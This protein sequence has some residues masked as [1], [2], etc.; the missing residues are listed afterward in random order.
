MPEKT[1]PAGVFIVDTNEATGLV[2]NLKIDVGLLDRA[3]RGDFVRVLLKFKKPAVPEVPA[4]KNPNTQPPIP[5]IPENP[6]AHE[7]ITVVVANRTPQGFL[8][9]RV[10]SR[11]QFTQL[12]SITYGDDLTISDRYV[13]SHE[14]STPATA[15]EMEPLL[16]G[17]IPDAAPINAEDAKLRD[18]IKN[19]PP[20]A[21]N[22]Q[23]QYWL[24]NGTLVTV[25]MFHAGVWVGAG[26]NGTNYE[27]LATGAHAGG[28]RE[29]DIVK[30]PKASEVLR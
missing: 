22:A 26:N 30:D 15:Q 7:F 14:Q 2:Q 27:W 23:Q 28:Q 1:L 18:A 9:G 3:R 4:G 8:K 29:L 24:R 25:Y 10:I 20:L 12:H 6:R 19:L 21:P 16:T 13:I 5:G 11:P 17:V